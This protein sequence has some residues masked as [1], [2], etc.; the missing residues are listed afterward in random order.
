M[1]Q[2]SDSRPRR[3][4]FHFKWHQRDCP[5]V[6]PPCGAAGRTGDCN[7]HVFRM[8]GE[9]INRLAV[10]VVFGIKPVRPGAGLLVAV[11]S[12][13]NDCSLAFSGPRIGPEGLSLVCMQKNIR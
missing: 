11:S 7:L 12:H 6:R 13:M 9:V 1:E 5:S 2:E 4:L 3:N 10:L 8:A